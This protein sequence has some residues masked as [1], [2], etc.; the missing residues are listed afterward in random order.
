[1]TTEVIVALI[2]LVGVIITVVA[3]NIKTSKQIKGQTDLTVYRI[4]QLEKKVDKHN[5]LVERMYGL[6]ERFA[7]L[8]NK[9]KV[10]DHRIGDLENRL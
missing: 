3:G 7:L 5:N 4:E 1:M 2:S 10:A 6:E 8:E 9:Q